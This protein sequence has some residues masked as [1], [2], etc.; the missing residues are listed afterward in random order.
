VVVEEGEEDGHVVWTLLR[1]GLNGE[2][3]IGSSRIRS[4]GKLG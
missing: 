2:D 1:A 3:W 4:L